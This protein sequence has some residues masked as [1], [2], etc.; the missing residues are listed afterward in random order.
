MP[1]P[2]EGVEDES[3]CEEVCVVRDDSNSSCENNGRRRRRRGGGQSLGECFC[4]KTSDGYCAY[5]AATSKLCLLMTRVTT[6][7]DKCRKTNLLEN[8]NNNRVDNNVSCDG[9]SSSLDLNGEE[10]EEEGKEQQLLLEEEERPLLVMECGGACSCSSNMCG[11]R[12]TQQGLAVGVAV[13]R[14]QNTGWGLHATQL[15]SKGSFVCEYAGM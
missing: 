3:C 4:G 1:L 12:V 14:K 7:A 5:D 9:M 6:T 13:V 2:S 15:I 8:I 11:F 10:E